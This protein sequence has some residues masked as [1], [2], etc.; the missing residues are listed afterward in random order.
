MNCPLHLFCKINLTFEEPL[1]SPVTT[2]GRLSVKGRRRLS[3]HPKMIRSPIL[4]LWVETVEAANQIGDASL[5]DRWISFTDSLS[6]KRKR[7][8]PKAP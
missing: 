2:S 1:I 5:A 7:A 3:Q 4:R 6:G 8:E